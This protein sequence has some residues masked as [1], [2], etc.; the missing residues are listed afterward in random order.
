MKAYRSPTD[1][2]FPEIVKFDLNFLGKAEPE[3][4]FLNLKKN[5]V[6]WITLPNIS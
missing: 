5:K 1:C 6:G 2:F 3:I 4:V